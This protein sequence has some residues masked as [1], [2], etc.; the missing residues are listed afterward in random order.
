MLKSF[1]IGMCAMV[2][3]AVLAQTAKAAEDKTHEGL[4]VSV[5]DGKLTMSDKD[6][7]NEHTHNIA[8][9]TRITL[10]GKAAKLTDLKKG[11]KVKVTVGAD[12][13]VSAI[14]GS[15]AAG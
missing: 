5:A 10:D 9:T 1:L 14:E 13:K 11:D 3:V 2:A 4:V 12:G 15:R 8:A 6:G 7:K